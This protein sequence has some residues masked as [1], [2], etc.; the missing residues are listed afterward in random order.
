MEWLSALKRLVTKQG[1]GLPAMFAVMALSGCSGTV[2]PSSAPS[3]EP[4]LTVIRQ[5]ATVTVTRDCPVNVSNDATPSYQVVELYVGDT[6]VVKP[7]SNCE[8]SRYRDFVQEQ[9][10]V[11]VTPT[12]GDTMTQLPR[13][14]TTQE[15]T[16]GFTVTALQETTNNCADTAANPFTTCLSQAHLMFVSYYNSTWGTTFNGAVFFSVRPTPPAAPLKPSVVAGDTQATVTVTGAGTGGTP[17]SFVVTSSPDSKTCT[18]SN[19]T[20]T[21]RS[22]SC[23]ITG[24]TNGTAYTFTAVASASAGTSGSSPPSDP[25]TP[26]PPSPNPPLLSAAA[27]NQDG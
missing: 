17:A 20:G 23:V 27:S 8:K 21:P 18:I 1:L 4:L 22:G 24:L 2:T 16:N 25:A 19:P 5:G 11:S 14:L 6:A 12:P 3:G 13:S 9:G 7:A 26:V 10:V 15:R